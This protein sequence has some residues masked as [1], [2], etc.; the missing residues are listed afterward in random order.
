MRNAY[1]IL[2]G[3][4]KGRDHWEVLGVERRIILKWGYNV[5]VWFLWLRIGAGQG[6]L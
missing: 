4:L 5:C 1:K 6:P 3:N 2:A